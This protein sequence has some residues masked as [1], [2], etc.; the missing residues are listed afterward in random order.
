MYNARYVKYF[1]LPEPSDHGKTVLMNIAKKKK[2]YTKYSVL[3]GTGKKLVEMPDLQSCAESFISAYR[4]NKL[5]KCILD[6]IL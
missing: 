4:E 2:C 3:S 5:G 1:N 6:D